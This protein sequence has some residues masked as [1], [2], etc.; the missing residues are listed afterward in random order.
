MWQ[1][2]IGMAVL[3]DS[4]PDTFYPIQHLNL[5]F[6]FVYCVIVIRITVTEEAKK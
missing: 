4:L 5:P 1:I 3:P 6:V 2:D